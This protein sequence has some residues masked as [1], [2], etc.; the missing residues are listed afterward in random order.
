M[1]A[2]GDEL[3][4]TQQGNNNV[5]CQD[6]ELSWIDWDLDDADA[7]L[8]EFTRMLV[9]LRR[10]HPILRRRRFFV[11]RGLEK[12]ADASH[13]EPATVELRPPDGTST[14]PSLSPADD[15]PPQV[16]AS[17]VGPDATARSS[18]ES[19]PTA[20]GRT[21]KPGATAKAGSPAATAEPD[22][23]D[24]TSA[25]D[26]TPEVL[27]DIEWFDI[28]GDRMDAVDWNNSYARSVMV[29]LN[30]DVI[31]ERDARGVPIV[32]DSFLML[33]NAHY[34]SLDFV[35]PAQEYGTTWTVVLDTDHS[36]EPGDEL[37]AGDTLTA[38]GRSVVV[39]T[40]DPAA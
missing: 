20:P 37:A 6:N 23:P 36:V 14:R 8:L 27:P 26:E 29:F 33:L 7:A 12:V 15:S 1:I 5:Y 19:G 17:A 16:A 2:H 9:K 18:A 21:A 40:R 10:E 25:A 3:G 34:E 30:G 35:L 24:E 4:R 39:L 22:G 11:G 38:E 31:S 32:D 13:L 28:T